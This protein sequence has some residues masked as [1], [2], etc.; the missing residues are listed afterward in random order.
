M[1]RSTIPLAALLVF[2]ASAAATDYTLLT[3]GAPAKALIPSA[4]NGGNA[5]GYQWQ[6]ETEPADL[7]SWLTGTTGVGYDSNPGGGGDYTPHI[8]LNVAAMMNTNGSV[9]IRI[10]F[11]VS[12]AERPLFKGL[13]LRMRY[14]DGFV[15]WINGT[16]VSSVLEPAS[17]AWNSNTLSGSTHDANLTAW[18]DFNISQHLSLLHDGENLLAIQGLNSANDSSDLLVVPQMLATDVVPP[19]EPHWPAPVFT[20]VPGVGQRARPVAI[21]HAGDGTGRLYMVEQGGRIQ[22]LTGATISLFLDINA[23]VLS[24]SDTGGGNE[25][26]LLGLAFPPGYAQS[27]RFYVSYTRSDR[28]LQLSRFR[29]LAAN[30]NAGDPDSEQILLTIPHAANTNHNGSDIHFGDDGY[31]Y[32]STGDGGG[33]GDTQNNAQNPL[34]LLGKMLRLDVEGHAGGGSLLPADNPWPLSTDGVADQIYH[35]GLRNPWRWSFDR[36][37]GDMWIGDVGQDISYEEVDVIPGNVPAKNFGWRRREGM[38]DF[39]LSQPYGPGTLTEPVVE[40]SGGDVSV[41][42]GYVYRGLKFPRMYG[43]Y[44]YG[45]YASGRFYGVAQDAG[46]TWR[47][48]TL[49]TDCNSVSTFGEDEAGELY[50]ANLSSGRVYRIDDGGSDSQFLRVVS[51]SVDPNGRATFTWGAANGE[52]YVPEVS[53]DMVNWSPAGPVQT[54]TATFR[55]TFTEAADPPPGTGRRYFRAREL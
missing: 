46:G 6:L 22:M 32:Y 16:K 1:N 30:P 37:T 40:K 19:A 53:T 41:T 42:G 23:R 31:L 24:N 28:A 51:H 35:L 8:G 45:D 18:E 4:A 47:S 54:G 52:S 9:F 2:C 3:A 10:P 50:W 5:P 13:T 20:E 29:T 39:N 27:R 38:H 7:A 21:R 12:A 33:G 44:F 17:L 48:S 49:R 26:G 11:T 36:V 34:S 15:V 55:L 25:Q 14:D 43:F